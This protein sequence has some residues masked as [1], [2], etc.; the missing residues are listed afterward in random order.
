MKNSLPNNGQKPD[1]VDW[2]EFKKTQKK[3]KETRKEG[4]EPSR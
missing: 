1:D 2:K 4:S 3:F